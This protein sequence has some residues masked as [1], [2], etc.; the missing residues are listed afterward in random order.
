[1][2]AGFQGGHDRPA[3]RPGTARDDGDPLSILTLGR[4]VHGFSTT[5]P[6]VAAVEHP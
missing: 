4:G 1:V 6:V 5:L 2:A 3:D